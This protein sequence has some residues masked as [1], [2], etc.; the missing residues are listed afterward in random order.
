MLFNTLLVLA[1]L[2]LVAYTAKPHLMRL[3][4]GVAR[5]RR[6]NSICRTRRARVA[7]R[8]AEQVYHARCAASARMT[9]PFPGA[10]Y[11]VSD[12]DAVRPGRTIKILDD[13]VVAYIDSYASTQIAYN[14]PIPILDRQALKETKK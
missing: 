14:H 11:P 6:Y 9:A 1:A 7:A 3:A 13:G 10:L 2:A 5:W 8:E 4:R 12:V